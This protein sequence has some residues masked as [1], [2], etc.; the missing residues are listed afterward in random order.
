MR[1]FTIRYGGC[2]KTVLQYRRR[3]ELKRGTCAVCGKG[4]SA[5]HLAI[6]RHMAV[7]LLKQDTT[8]KLG[9]KSKRKAVGWDNGCLLSLL[10]GNLDA[11]ALINAF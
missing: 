5:E 6:L 8:V 11:W 9:I 2:F 4:N 7:N 3:K 1:V 10:N